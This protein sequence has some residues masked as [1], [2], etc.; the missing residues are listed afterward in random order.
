M[1]T[2]GHDGR[3]VHNELEAHITCRVLCCQAGCMQRLLCIMG[4]SKVYEVSFCLTW[5]LQAWKE[6][7]Q[8]CLLANT[9][10]G[11][12]GIALDLSW[13]R[14]PTTRICMKWPRPDVSS[15]LLAHCI[16][17]LCCNDF[18]QFRRM[19]KKLYRQVHVN[20]L[21]IGCRLIAGLQPK[22]QSKLARP[23]FPWN[24]RVN[25]L[26]ATFLYFLLIHNI[27]WGYCRG[28]SLWHQVNAA[29]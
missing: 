9:L 13:V 2:R 21:R 12:F 16:W 26:F 25:C 17:L 7:L 5:A 10:P 4:C 14:L 6:A 23:S 8:A 19:S 1:I 18:R 27:F 3:L 24:K 15:A 28:A 11:G 20:V 22:K 29:I